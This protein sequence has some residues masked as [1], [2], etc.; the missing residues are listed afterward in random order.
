MANRLQRCRLHDDATEQGQPAPVR[1]E[2]F[3]ALRHGLIGYE[4]SR[5]TPCWKFP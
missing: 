4:T 3:P 2:P 5:P 1:G